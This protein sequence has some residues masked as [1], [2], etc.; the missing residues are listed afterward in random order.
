M[1]GGGQNQVRAILTGTLAGAQTGLSGIPKRF[2]D[3][4]ENADELLGL[5]R[6]LAAQAVP[7]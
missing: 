1:N 6:K 5:A 3:G 2:F 4:L 7:N